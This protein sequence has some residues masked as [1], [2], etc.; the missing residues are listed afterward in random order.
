[1]PAVSAENRRLVCVN[2]WTR[3][4][5][6]A[7]LAFRFDGPSAELAWGYHL[8]WTENEHASDRAVA[9]PRIASRLLDPSED[10]PIVARLSG[11]AAGPSDVF[12]DPCWLERE[13]S[14]GP[15]RTAG[16]RIGA[17]AS[18]CRSEIHRPVMHPDVVVPPPAARAQGRPGRSR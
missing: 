2:G 14:A 12:G 16:P 18:R 15:A 11:D 7:D 8:T 13:G 4:G 6:I 3:L 1:M 9:V 17:E 10:W 5:M